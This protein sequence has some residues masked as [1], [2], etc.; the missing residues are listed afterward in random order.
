MKRHY[1][2][3]N[4]DYV[5][6]RAVAMPI[7]N[8]SNFTIDGSG[9]EF[10]FHECILPIAVVHLRRMDQECSHAL[11]KRLDFGAIRSVV[12]EASSWQALLI[13]HLRRNSVTCQSVQVNA[14]HIGLEGAPLAFPSHLRRILKR[15]RVL[16]PLDFQER[17]PH[18]QHHPGLV[19]K[20]QESAEILVGWFCS[21][22]GGSGPNWGR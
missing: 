10:I 5:K 22:F 9:S 15:D 18:K 17:V 13:G 16:L 2:I 1:F 7:E 6:S 20:T 19:C 11:G 14:G 12:A 8:V 3:S 21:C 4:H